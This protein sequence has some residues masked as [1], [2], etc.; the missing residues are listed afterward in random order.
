[1]KVGEWHLLIR[2][3]FKAADCWVGAFWKRSHVNRFDLWLCLLP[4]LPLHLAASRI[5]RSIPFH[6]SGEPRNER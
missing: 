3:E 1:M 2:P 4:M 6:A 5:P